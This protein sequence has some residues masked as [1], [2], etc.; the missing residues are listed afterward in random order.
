[1]LGSSNFN[2]D[3]D[4]IVYPSKNKIQFRLKACPICFLK[5]L[6]MP[7]PAAL[8]V[9][10]LVA[11]SSEGWRLS[12]NLLKISQTL[13][14]ISAENFRTK[15]GNC[16]IFGTKN[17]VKMLVK[18]INTTLQNC[19]VIV[20]VLAVAVAANIFNTNNLIEVSNSPLNLATV[21]S[22]LNL[23]SSVA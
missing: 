22:P 3:A 12:T 6:Q 15:L 9:N 13:G 1:M 8:C 19:Y 14:L 16:T 4:S 11:T 5:F 21:T 18:L 2:F 20:F 23:I 10:L 7:N 17:H